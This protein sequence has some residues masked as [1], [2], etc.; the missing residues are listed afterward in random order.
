MGF[1]HSIDNE[2]KCSAPGKTIEVAW[3]TIGGQRRE[4]VVLSRDG[5]RRTPG[6]SV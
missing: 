5:V 3:R 2:V 6:G 1:S 4:Y